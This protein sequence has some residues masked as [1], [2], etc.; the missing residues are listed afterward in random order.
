MKHRVR[1]KHDA[2]REYFRC[3]YEGEKMRLK[4]IYKEIKKEAKKAVSDAKTKAYME[5]YRIWRRKKGNIECS[6][7]QKFE[8]GGRETFKS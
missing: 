4:H 8:R 6:K 5:I 7:S 3:I 2:F 1:E